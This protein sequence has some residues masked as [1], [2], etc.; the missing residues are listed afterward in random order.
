MF[1]VELRPPSPPSLA[2]LRLYLERILA[3][4]C[5]LSKGVSTDRSYIRCV[6]RHQLN[7]VRGL[8]KVGVD[9]LLGKQRKILGQHVLDTTT[10]SPPGFRRSRRQLRQRIRSFRAVAKS[11]RVHGA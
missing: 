10:D 2:C 3:R 4:L 9:C 8:E 5:L 6:T 1:I 7:H 11:G